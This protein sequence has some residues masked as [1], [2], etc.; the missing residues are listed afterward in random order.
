MI[1]LEQAKEQIVEAGRRLWL[2][3]LVAASDGNISCRLADG[4]FLITPS[5]V[6]KGFLGPDDLLLV[7]E[8]GNVLSGTGRP[9]IETALHLAVYRARPDIRALVHAHPPLTTAF[10]LTGQ[11]MNEDAPDEVKLQLGRIAVADYG[12]AGSGELAQNVAKAARSGAYAVLL[13]RHGALTAGDDPLRAL[14]RMEALEQAAKTM[15][16]ARL[17][18]L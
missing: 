13:S 11:D 12:E 16:A 2:R 15:L 5:G 9:S 10:T 7:D 3:G 1:E 14:F 18:R 6:A 17:L 8:A 4:A